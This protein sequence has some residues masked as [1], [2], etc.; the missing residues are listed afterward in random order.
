MIY[1]VQHCHDGQPMTSEIGRHNNKLFLWESW[2]LALI[3]TETLI[4]GL[5]NSQSRDTKPTII[6]HGLQAHLYPQNLP[7]YLA[8]G[9]LEL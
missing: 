3:P 7:A 5:G 2:H 9:E 4:H 6:F 1:P 8:P